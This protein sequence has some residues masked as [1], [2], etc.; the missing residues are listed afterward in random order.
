MDFHFSG[1]HSQMSCLTTW[2]RCLD[3]KENGK[4]SH[5]PQDKKG[6]NKC[7]KYGHHDYHG[8]R[9]HHG[10][11]GHRGHYGPHSHLPLAKKGFNMEE[12]DL[13]YYVYETKVLCSG[14]MIFTPGF[15]LHLWTC[16]I[17]MLWCFT[18][19]WQFEKNCANRSKFSFSPSHHQTN[20][21]RYKCQSQYNPEQWAYLYSNIW[22]IMKMYFIKVVWK[23]MLVCE[24]WNKSLSPYEHS[25]RQISVK[26]TSWDDYWLLD[27]RVCEPLLVR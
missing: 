25:S 9:G 1:A 14:Q 15:S 2:L 13:L 20:S 17:N 16:P 21:I 10:L 8:H 24:N 18:F 7:E 3:Q 27:V 12:R 5:L 22:Y 11:H 23:Y 19:P 26:P 4:P 6:S